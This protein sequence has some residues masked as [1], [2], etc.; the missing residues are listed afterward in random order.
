MTIVEACVVVFEVSDSF[1]IV[2]LTSLPVRTLKTYYAYHSLMF[3]IAQNIGLWCFRVIRFLKS[4]DR[5]TSKVI[6]LG[7][8]TDVHAYYYY[9]YY[10]AAIDTDQS[11][12]I[13]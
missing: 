3:Y 6:K 4:H 8:N 9:Y 1:I 7:N 10:G 13:H 5:Y 12:A 2:V 11:V